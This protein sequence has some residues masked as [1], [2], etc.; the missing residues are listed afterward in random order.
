LNLKDHPKIRAEKSPLRS[1][2]SVLIHGSAGPKKSSGIA[3]SAASFN[4]GRFFGGNFQ[5]TVFAISGILLAGFSVKFI[6]DALTRF[7]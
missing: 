2:T 1:I 4:G 5:K 6:Y 7:Y 3:L